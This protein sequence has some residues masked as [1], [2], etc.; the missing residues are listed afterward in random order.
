MRRRRRPREPRSPCSSPLQRAMRIVRLGL[1]PRA[2]RIRTASIVATTP[3]PLSV[4]P[5]PPCQES[6]WAPSMT[7]S[8]F[9][10]D[11]GNLGDRVPLHRVVFE[12]ARLDVDLELDVAPCSSRRAIAPKVLDGHGQ[13]WA[14][15]PARPSSR[16]LPALHD[17]TPPSWR[18]GATTASAFSSTKS[19]RSRG[20]RGAR[21]SLF[22]VEGARPAAVQAARRPGSRTRRAPRATSRRSARRA[23][24]P[25]GLT[26]A[27][28]AEDH[29]LAGELALELLEVLLARDA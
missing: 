15:P 9:L 4:A 26:S 21:S 5:V 29:D 7:T 28:L 11:P 13:R 14:G 25:C 23:P 22:A 19:L 27:H 18:P 8:P 17:V 24:C 2:F 20:T 12:E 3:A 10:S 16:C 1:T 6:R